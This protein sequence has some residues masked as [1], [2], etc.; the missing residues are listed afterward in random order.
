ME[1][2]METVPAK[3]LD[4]IRSEFNLLP[5]SASPTTYNDEY[6]AKHKDSVPAVLSAMRVRKLLS[7]EATSSCEKD[8]AAAIKLPNITMEEAK[9]ALEL[10]SSWQS[11]EVE[12]F[13]LS[14][15]SKWPKASV[16]AAST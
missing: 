12:S 14:A 7:P 9:A 10:L 8:A 11:A 13:K 6:F 4:I 15:A 5:S 1:K 16:F 2:D 3:S